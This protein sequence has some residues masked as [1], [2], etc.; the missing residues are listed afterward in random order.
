MKSALTYLYSSTKSV[1]EERSQ[2]REWRR[3][4]DGNGGLRV[5]K[6]GVGEQRER[7]RRFTMGGLGGGSGRGGR[8]RGRGRGRGGLRLG[9][10]GWG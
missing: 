2:N 5:S 8:G 9:D 7:E 4:Y 3:T 6:L 1:A 10:W